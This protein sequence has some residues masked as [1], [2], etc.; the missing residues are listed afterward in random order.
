MRGPKGG[1][2]VVFPGGECAIYRVESVNWDRRTG[3]LT[4]QQTGLYW[5]IGART[6]RSLPGGGSTGWSGTGPGG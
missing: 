6:F 4:L 1:V 2:Q 5:T 3:T